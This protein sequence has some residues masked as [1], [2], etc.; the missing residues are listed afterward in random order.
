MPLSQQPQTHG[1][2]TRFGRSLTFLSGAADRRRKAR[3]RPATLAL[4][5]ID[6]DETRRSASQADHPKPLRWW[7]C[8]ASQLSTSS[9]C[10]LLAQSTHDANPARDTPVH[11]DRGASSRQ[12]GPKDPRLDP[13]DLN[14]HRRCASPHG[15]NRAGPQ[16][17]PTG[18]NA[19]R[20]SRSTSHD[21]D[22][23]VPFPLIH[24]AQ[25]TLRPSRPAT[26][27]SLGPFVPRVGR[28]NVV[29]L[30]ADNRRPDPRRR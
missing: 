4:L 18:A 9:S 28:S 25:S 5:A 2:R 3:R 16:R 6:I 26:D 1:C 8:R 23:S 29:E 15:S 10:H 19:V 7:R 11:L 30:T 17:L 14:A 24:E 12:L 27:F 13:L 22:Q 20:A 21:P